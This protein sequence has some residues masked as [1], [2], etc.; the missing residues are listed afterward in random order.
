MAYSPGLD[1]KRERRRA[2]QWRA[3]WI[4]RFTERQRVIRKWINFAEIAEWCSKD[5]QSIV[6]KK[7]KRKA[8]FDALTDLLAGE[9][10]ENGRSLVL[11]LN[12]E[13]TKF[14]MNRE[15]IQEVIT[16]DYDGDEGRSQYLSH[17]WIPRRLF[18]Q[19][20]IKHRQPES[21]HFQPCRGKFSSANK[22]TKPAGGPWGTAESGLKKAGRGRPA[23]YNWEGV[24]AK[25]AD[26]VSKHG[27]MQTSDELLQK[28]EDFA[29]DLHPENKTPS[30][31]TIR[32]AIMKHALDVAAGVSG[33]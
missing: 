11:Y 26:Y 31:K 6:P 12:P 30:D 2:Q 22:E 25:L 4:A 7:E 8:V 17:C 5:D 20:R 28:C 10:E 18:E 15:S 23:E 3:G 9:F 1:R 29:S 21:P 19:W 13:I 27:P 32:E 24:K 33:K 14:R 16:Y